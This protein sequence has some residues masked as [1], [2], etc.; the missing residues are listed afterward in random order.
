MRDLGVVDPM[1]VPA[2]VAAVLARFRALPQLAQAFIVIAV[3]DALVRTI[4]LIEPHARFDAGPIS[5]VGSYVPRDLWI[6]LPAILL[7]RRMTAAEDLPA[8]LR[9]ALIV[10][11]VTL[12]AQPTIVLLSDL[13]SA[14]EPDL[15]L[16]T[17]L[18]LAR[19]VALTVAYVL[20]GRGLGALNPT[21]PRPVVAGLGNLI[22]WAIVLGLA[23]QLIAGVAV[24]AFHGVDPV[25]N[26]ASLGGTIAAQVGLAYFLRAVVRGMD[27][28]SRAE[29]ATR[30]A[31]AG[32]A[33]LA[34]SIV[35][36]AILSILS[37]VLQGSFAGQQTLLGISQW[38]TTVIGVLDLTGYILLI[39]AFAIGL[40]DPLRP[41][42]K[43]WETAAAPA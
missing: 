42:A 20:L 40:A 13:T 34:V 11:I 9:G 5:A 39:A 28:P 38:S 7:V 12:V 16:F 21:L 37:A 29:R 6:L 10:A 35:F 22:G 3:A 31:S 2:P 18:A 27:D 36:E 32:A 23:G 25:F 24:D 17:V 41:M 14:G 19:D 15:S 1:R 30:T 43:D 33:L 8:L 4:G 26:A